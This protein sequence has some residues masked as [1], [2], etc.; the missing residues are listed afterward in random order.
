MIT[1][2]LKRAG[3]RSLLGVKVYLEMPLSVVGE[4]EEDVEGGK[5]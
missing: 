4:D 5:G 3:E 2:G 1:D